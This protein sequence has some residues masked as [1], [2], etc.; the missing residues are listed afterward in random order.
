MD[1]DDLYNELYSR[2]SLNQ[3]DKD[4]DAPDEQELA[5][6]FLE[7]LKK[8]TL[9]LSQK[10]DNEILDIAIKKT[11][12]LNN[13]TEYFPAYDVALKLKNNNWKPTEKQRKAI[14]NV[15]AF[16][17]TRYKLTGGNISCQ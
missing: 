10:T 6:Y 13:V 17:I 9:S 15:T 7:L 5:E 8:I 12:D 4:W 2:S 3:F 16:Y 1:L 14:I 11:N